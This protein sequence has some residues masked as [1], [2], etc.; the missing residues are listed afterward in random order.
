MI[1]VLCC[2]LV[3]LKLDYIFESLGE[4]YP[5]PTSFPFSHSGYTQTDGMRIPGDGTYATP[6]NSNS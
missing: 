6:V 4:Y 5:K 3:E 1:L 2:R